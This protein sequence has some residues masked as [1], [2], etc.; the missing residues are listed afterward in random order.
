MI[1]RTLCLPLFPDEPA[2]THCSLILCIGAS[3][4]VNGHGRDV[5]SV[6]I[7]SPKPVM[8]NRQVASMHA[9][10]CRDVWIGDVLWLADVENI[11]DSD[12]ED[13]T[14]RP[15]IRYHSMHPRSVVG[16]EMC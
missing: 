5:P 4:L 11:V 1:K 2:H 9:G 16:L 15:Q 3:G 14:Y 10:R 13:E 6:F 12:W 8:K 7:S